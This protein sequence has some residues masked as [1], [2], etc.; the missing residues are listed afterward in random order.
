MNINHQVVLVS[1]PPE[2]WNPSGVAPDRLGGSSIQAKPQSFRVSGYRKSCPENKTAKDTGCASIAVLCW[3]RL[4]R[5]G[6]SR[7]AI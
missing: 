1:K 5:A 7:A 6:L 4:C 2:G 3:W